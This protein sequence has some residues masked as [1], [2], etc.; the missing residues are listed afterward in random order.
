MRPSHNIQYNYKHAHNYKTFSECW[1]M[2]KTVHLF[3]AN[4]KLPITV[5]ARDFFYV[6]PLI[7]KPGHTV[8]ICDIYIL[9]STKSFDPMT[10]F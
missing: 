4:H 2:E 1:T 5:S 8:V 7:A 3:I 6:I 9:N 10:N